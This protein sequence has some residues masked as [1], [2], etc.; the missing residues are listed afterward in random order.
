MY[1]ALHGSLPKIPGLPG[2]AARFRTERDST[3]AAAEDKCN[4][5]L[6]GYRFVK[7]LSLQS[8]RSE[9]STRL[10]VGQCKVY[11]CNSVAIGVT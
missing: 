6:I 3:T 8:Q 1:L 2:T 4:C 7:H 10:L 11:Q 5:V 9:L